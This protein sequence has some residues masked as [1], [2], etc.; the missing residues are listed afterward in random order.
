MVY[1]FFF[2]RNYSY[3]L[4]E[5]KSINVVFFNIYGYLGTAG[6]RLGYNS[7]DYPSDKVYVVARRLRTP[8][9]NASV[10]VT[11]AIIRTA[12]Q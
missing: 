9:S 10:E 2:N 12:K 5:N 7:S 11:A 1:F 3:V 4:Y 6:R 8:H